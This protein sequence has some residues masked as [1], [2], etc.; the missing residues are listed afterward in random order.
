MLSL[1]FANM[2]KRKKPVETESALRKKARPARRKI[3]SSGRK[4][5]NKGQDKD[6]QSCPKA[7]SYFDTKQ[8]MSNQDLNVLNNATSTTCTEGYNVDTQNGKVYLG[9]KFNIAPGTNQPNKEYDRI[10]EATRSMLYQMSGAW[11]KE[12][13]VDLNDVYDCVFERPTFRSIQIQKTN[14]IYIQALKNTAYKH[15]EDGD[16][17]NGYHG[18]QKQKPAPSLPVMSLSVASRPRQPSQQNRL[19]QRLRALLPSPLQYFIYNY[20][21]LI[22]I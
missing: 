19:S 15:F 1:S 13:A 17:N 2:K 11:D 5:P 16:T 3:Q 8:R 22:R 4:R 9:T 21:A 7:E 6:K 14:Y 18:I 10:V 20:L 12:K